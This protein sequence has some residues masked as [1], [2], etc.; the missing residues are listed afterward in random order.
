MVNG[1]TKPLKN[2][3]GYSN[4]AVVIEEM[5]F[6]ELAGFLEHSLSVIFRGIN[7]ILETSLYITT[8]VQKTRLNTEAS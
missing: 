1:C 7:S 8:S 5:V 6:L 2:D 3:H 4:A